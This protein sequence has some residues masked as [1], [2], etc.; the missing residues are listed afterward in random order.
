M[1]WFNTANILFSTLHA[2]K[3]KLAHSP[4]ASGIR[5]PKMHVWENPKVIY[6]LIQ[7]GMMMYIAKGDLTILQGRLGMSKADVDSLVGAISSMEVRHDFY[8]GRLKVSHPETTRKGASKKDLEAK[9]KFQKVEP[10]L[11]PVEKIHNTI[12]KLVDWGGMVG[13]G[14]AVG[15]ME[16]GVN[17]TKWLTGADDK[18]VGGREDDNQL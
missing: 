18:S 9:A 7:D 16:G 1:G 15:S 8:S 11:K 2:S 6:E 4:K 14:G 10:T 17:W 3:T 5:I 13:E 12:T